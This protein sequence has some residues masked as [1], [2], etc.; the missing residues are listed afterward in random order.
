MHPNSMETEAPML[1]ILLDTEGPKR[2][3]G[4]SSVSSV[5]SFI[6]IVN[7]SKCFQVS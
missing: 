2:A 5:I 7:L 1:R 3:P 6:I 4:Y